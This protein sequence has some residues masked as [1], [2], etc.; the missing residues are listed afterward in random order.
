M[1]KAKISENNPFFV[2]P[3]ETLPASERDAIR[4]RMR[5]FGLLKNGFPV[6]IE[7]ELAID[8]KGFSRWEVQIKNFNDI[9]KS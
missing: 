5:E 1:I 2:V 3:C 8:K 4:G 6:K 7:A 9:K